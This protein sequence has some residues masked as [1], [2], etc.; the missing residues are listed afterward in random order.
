LGRDMAR[1]L[2]KQVKLDIDGQHT[3]VD[4]DVLEKLEAP[5][6]HLLRNAIDHGIESPAER[7]AA[8]KPEQGVVRLEVRHRAGMLAITVSDD[9]K[10]INLDRLRRKILERR[11]TAPELVASMTD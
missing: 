3:E 2:G 9:G 7:M 8:G 4:R 10:G 5:L 11:L 1:S 6:T